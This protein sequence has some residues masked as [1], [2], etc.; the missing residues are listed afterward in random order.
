MDAIG[1]GGFG[2]VFKVK[3]KVDGKYFAMKYVKEVEN[4]EKQAVI[5]EASLIAHLNSEE[6]IKCV[7][8]YYWKN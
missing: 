1:Q 7:D 8:L 3:R 6:M 4:A 5:N 2:E